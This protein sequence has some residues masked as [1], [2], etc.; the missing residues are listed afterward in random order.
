MPTRCPQCHTPLTVEAAQ[1]AAAPF[2][3]PRCKLLDLGGW[4]G[5][6]YRISEPLDT[7]ELTALLETKDQQPPS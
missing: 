1:T 6:R 4:L 5:E 2:C 3:S 7:A